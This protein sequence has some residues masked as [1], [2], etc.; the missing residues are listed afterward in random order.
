MKIDV[1]VPFHQK[2]ADTFRWCIQGI[3]Q[4]I[5]FSRVIAITHK[6]SKNHVID[7]GADFFDEEHVIKGLTA[8]SQSFKLWGWYYQQ[9]LKLGMA[10]WVDTDYYLVVDSDTVFL[11][12]VTFF[13]DNGKP[14]YCT[15]NEYHKP[16]FQSFENILG[17]KA[18]REYSFVTHHMVFNRY[19]VQEMQKKFQT[20]CVWYQ[21]I[22]NTAKTSMHAFS[23]YETYGH[24]IKNLHQEEL[25]LRSLEWANIAQP[26]SK[27]LFKRLSKHYDYCSTHLYLRKDKSYRK[28]IK[29]R[30]K[31]ET[32]ILKK[33]LRKSISRITNRGS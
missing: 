30:V 18:Q 4:N 15:G 16:Y 10:N 8:Q 17:F 33:E 14:L 1:I 21:Q 20:D 24:Y 11:N 5:E 32:K 26:P 7:A 29:R 3:K 9:I 13:T 28:R 12:P 6:L 31:F 19:I 22:I 27:K 25:N 2:D 23:E